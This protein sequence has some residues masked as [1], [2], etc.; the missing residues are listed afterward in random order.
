MKRWMVGDV[1]GDLPLLQ[2][3]MD[4]LG[5]T[6][7]DLVLF[8]GSYLGP[9][10]DSKGV[11]QYILDAQKKLP[12]QIK[13]LRGCYEY[14]F[15]L[16]CGEDADWVVA[17]LWR[18]MGGQKVFSS[19]SSGGKPITVLHT[20]NGNG[21]SMFKPMKTGPVKVEIPLI[22]PE[23]HVGFMTGLPH[24]YE[25]D[26]F[27]YIGTHSGGHPALFGGSF[28]SEEEVVFS[29]NEWWSQDW[30]QIHGKTVV[31]SHVP[32]KEPFRGPGK[33]G[34]DLGAGM[35]GKLAAFELMSE[36]FTVVGE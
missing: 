33:L 19:Y 20:G 6:E 18:K 26:I 16:V 22:I 7:S 17:D 27:P 4:K 12:N 15:P 21:N 35:G 30:R 3:L 36:T 8:L 9:G 2:R 10:P 34:I 13:C 5:P 23:A 28:G 14:V 25:D 24:W 1:R 31:F 29:E 11:I 32:F